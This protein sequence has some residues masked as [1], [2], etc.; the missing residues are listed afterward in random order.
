MTKTN[1]ITVFEY[2]IRKVKQKPSGAANLRRKGE[3]N[4]KKILLTKKQKDIIDKIFIHYVENKSIFSIYFKNSDDVVWC[5]TIS[6]I[7][8][9]IYEH[10]KF[11]N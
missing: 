3:K 1:G 5:N 4:E 9:A 11:K 8:L 2:Y 7:Y 10:L 6:E